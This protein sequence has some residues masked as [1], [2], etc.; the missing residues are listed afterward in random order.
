MS[1]RIT[2]SVGS[3]QS[4]A[5][6]REKDIRTVQELLTAAARKLKD[7]RLDPGG[8]DGKIHRVA[9]RSSTVKAITHFQKVQVGLNRPDQRIDV[10]GKTWNKLM[11]VVGRAAPKQPSK[12]IGLLTLTVSH[13]G[14]VPTGTVRAKG[15]SVGTYN[16]AYESSFVLSGGLTGRF[17]GSIWPNNMTEKGHLVDGSYPLHLGF[18]K[19]GGAAKQT[20]DNL[21]VKNKGVRAGLLVNMRNAVSVQSDN[22]SKTSSSGI[23]IH[24]GLSATKRSSDGCLNLP[25][26]D[27]AKFMQLIL[28]AYPNIKDWH[29]EYKNTGK[30]IGTLIVQ[31]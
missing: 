22:S 17:R 7:P 18:H 12:P 13:G 24:N 30:K 20:A 2:G 4:G 15:K 6:N 19:G 26:S 8:I 16:G 23:N 3:Y 11:N 10:G 31:Q 1:T 27:W 29:Q 28:D 21:V 5:V 14:L 25:P 9:S